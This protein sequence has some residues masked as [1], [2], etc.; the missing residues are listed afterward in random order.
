[1]AKEFFVRFGYKGETIEE[2]AEAISSEVNAFFIEMNDPFIG[3]QLVAD[4]CAADKI[5]VSQ[6]YYPEDD[7]WL[8]EEHKECPVMISATFSRSSK[9]TDNEMKALVFKGAL[10]NTEG[11]VF[12]DIEGRDPKEFDPKEALKKIGIDMDEAAKVLPGL[13][14]K[15]N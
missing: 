5:I 2:A 9:D 1:M 15:D 4:E 13:N 10:E 12:V 14:E 6:N 11:M 3:K 7:I 8:C